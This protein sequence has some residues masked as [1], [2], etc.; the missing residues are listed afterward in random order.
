M[1]EQ[2]VMSN[3]GRSY[4]CYAHR[5]ECSVFKNYTIIVDGFMVADHNSTFR[6]TKFSHLRFLCLFNTT[7]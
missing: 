3:F 5:L 4:C 2:T 7:V 1:F 6:K